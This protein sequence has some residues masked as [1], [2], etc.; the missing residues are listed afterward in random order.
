MKAFLKDIS[1]FFMGE[2]P[3]ELRRVLVVQVFTKMPVF[4]NGNLESYQ[5]DG[6]FNLNNQSKDSHFL[7]GAEERT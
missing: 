3:I 2:Y 7:L 1:K 5:I 4:V 6:A